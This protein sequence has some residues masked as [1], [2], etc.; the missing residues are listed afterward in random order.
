M[1]HEE[2]KVEYEEEALPFIE[3]QYRRIITSYVD[4]LEA[5]IAELE[6]Q[7]VSIQKT[8]QICF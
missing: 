3:K 7:L 5:R 8:Y 1:I 4:E 6:S 2:T